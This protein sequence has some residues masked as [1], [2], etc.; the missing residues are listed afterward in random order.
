MEQPGSAVGGQEGRPEG[1][2][3]APEIA[4]QVE[5]ELEQPIARDDIALPEEGIVHR[6]GAHVRNAVAILDDLDRR[7][8][9]RQGEW[10]LPPPPAARRGEA[11]RRE[12][13]GG[14]QQK[15]AARHDENSGRRHDHA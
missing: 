6:S 7:A 10:P 3:H 15:R 8:Q 9:P 5:V 13:G 1:L 12:G 14:G 11:A 4:P 2:R